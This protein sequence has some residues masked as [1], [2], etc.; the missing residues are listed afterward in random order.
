MCEYS[1]Y[2]DGEKPRLYCKLNKKACIFSKYCIKQKKYIHKEGVDNCYMAINEKRKI[3]PNGAYYVRFVRKGYVYVEI[4]DK[5]IKIKDT[6]GNI[7]NYVYL[8]Q[9]EQGEYTI[10][11]T[12][13][14]LTPI[15]KKYNRKKK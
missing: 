13:F 11:L 8:Q 2:E 5:V 6:I 4:D 14:E 10:S 15:K 3:I 9:N 7:T 1:Y 12:P